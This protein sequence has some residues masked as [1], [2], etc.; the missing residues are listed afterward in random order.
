M[1]EEGARARILY[2]SGYADDQLANEGV[3]GER[4][5]FLAKPYTGT[6][7]LRKVREVL[8]AKTSVAGGPP[9]A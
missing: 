9:P 8:D 2:T 1:R 5:H 6:T 7:L 3:A 4:V